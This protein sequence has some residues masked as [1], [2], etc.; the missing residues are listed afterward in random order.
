MKLCVC[1]ALAALFVLQPGSLVGGEEALPR[2]A[3]G[4]SAK[5]FPD[6][7]AKDAH[8]AVRLW[9]SELGRQANMTPESTVYPDVNSMFAEF[10]KGRLDF[11]VI[12]AV[13]FLKYE[14][15]LQGTPGFVG[16]RKGKKTERYALLVRAEK[17]S[18]RLSELKQRR[19]ALV[20]HD[21]L[22]MLFLNTVLLS[23]R[24]PEMNRFFSSV[25]FKPKH[26]QA[27]HAVYFGAAD[28]CVVPERAF[29]SMMELNPQVGKKL[30]AIE[31]SPELIPGVA[32]FRKTY[33]S[34]LRTRMDEITRGLKNNPRG[35]QILA[36]FQ[37]DDLAMM[38]DEDLADMRKLYREYRRFSGRLL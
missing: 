9:A 13:D 36:L 30:L 20:A 19:L 5:S 14:N 22:S 17:G 33:P 11:I 10:R 23:Q 38:L 35:K 15:S 37:F 28:A 2:I 3:I 12:P 16:V 26:S 7:D 8:A 18:V 1:V 25:V 24:H 34:M 29:E 6:V 21:D 31:F 32:I 27:I 4:F